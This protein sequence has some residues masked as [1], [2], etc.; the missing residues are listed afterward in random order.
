MSTSL[1]IS[2][3]NPDNGPAIQA[4]V[5]AGA[6]TIILPPGTLQ[7]KTPTV[8]NHLSG[9][10]LRAVARGATAL[11]GSGAFL[12]FINC[13]A[14]GIED[15]TLVGGGYPAFTLC[16]RFWARN[17][18]FE[19]FSEFGVVV[20]GGSW[21]WIENS[22]FN[23][24][25]SPQQNEAVLVSSSAGQTAQGWICRN[26]LYG[27]GT[28]IDG[29]N[30]TFEGNVVEN[31]GFGAGFTGELSSTSHQHIVRGNTFIGGQGFDANEAYCSGVE[32]YAPSSTYSDNQSY[33]NAG[34]GYVIAGPCSVVIGNRAAGN[35]LK[36]LNLFKNPSVANC[37]PSGSLV[38]G[39]LV[40]TFNV[41]PG[42]TLAPGSQI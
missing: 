37:D 12:Q 34:C 33:N 36:D 21:F 40:N 8:L 10:T 18:D 27:S 5:S 15:L 32:A 16:N 39:N 35:K 30:I 2:P 28:D 9:I 3:S 25:P 6:G 17:C 31:W 23:R 38:T 1:T 24:Q 11:S 14:V 41:Y 42:V 20:N 4:A 22:L 29:A 26:T 7:I 13:A 19:N